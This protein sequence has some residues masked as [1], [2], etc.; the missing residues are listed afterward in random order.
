V[1][2]CLKVSVDNFPSVILKNNN[3]HHDHHHWQKHQTIRIK[4]Q[5]WQ[6]SSQDV[7]NEHGPDGAWRRFSFLL[8]LIK[9]PQ[10]RWNIQICS[11]S[12]GVSSQLLH[13]SQLIVPVKLSKLSHSHC[14][15]PGCGL[16]LPPRTEGGY[17]DGCNTCY[18]SFLS[19]GS[20]LSLRNGSWFTVLSE[21]ILNLSLQNRSSSGSL[22]PPVS[23]Q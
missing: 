19:A 16:S 20:G 23:P 12:C 1:Y 8:L 18:R 11:G 4:W 5:Q 3:H 17:V 22:Q 14:S 15:S 7:V 10:W 2:L 13:S 6:R 9:T 21:K